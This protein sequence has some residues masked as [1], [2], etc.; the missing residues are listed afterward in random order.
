MRAF[1]RRSGC[2]L[3]EGKERCEGLL[4]KKRQRPSEKRKA[5][6]AAR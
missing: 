1:T 6:T 5:E 3:A 2:T 4:V